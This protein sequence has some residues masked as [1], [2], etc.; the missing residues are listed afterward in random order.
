[1][2]SRVKGFETLLL[3]EWVFFSFK[4]GPYLT[5]EM[6]SIQ[7][8]SRSEMKRKPGGNAHLGVVI[9]IE[10]GVQIIHLDRTNPK[11][12]CK[13]KVHTAAHC[14]GERSAGINPKLRTICVGDRAQDTQRSHHVSAV[15]ATHHD[16]RKGL[17]V[18]DS[19]H[20]HLRSE[21]DRSLLLLNS[22]RLPILLAH[23]AHQSK[24]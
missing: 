21:Q 24:P 16:V 23:I 17:H 22:G 20:G 9:G 6:P 12:P 11:R 3:D 15:D 5:M 18:L 13:F 14:R 4:P 1:M 2:T 8:D 19:G 7:I 10:I